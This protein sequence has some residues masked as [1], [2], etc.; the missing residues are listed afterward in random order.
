MDKEI[1]DVIDKLFEEAKS[2]NEESFK[3]L[4]E[5][6]LAATHKMIDITNREHNRRFLID[7]YK[8]H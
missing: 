8:K 7:H 3:I 1:V 5:I 6:F 2:G 4:G